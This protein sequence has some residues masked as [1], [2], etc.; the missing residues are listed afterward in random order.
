[1]SDTIRLEESWK[2]ALEPEFSSPYMTKLKAFRKDELSAGKWI[3]PKGKNGGKNL[4]PFLYSVR[5]NF[6]FPV[7]A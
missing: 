4:S 7:P 5:V 6:S 3:F 2:A 1:M